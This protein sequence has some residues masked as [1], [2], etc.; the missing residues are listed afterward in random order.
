[1]FP[2]CFLFFINIVNDIVL[3]ISD[4]GVGISPE[5]LPTILSGNGT[6]TSGGTNILLLNLNML[7]Q[8]SL[9]HLVSIYVFLILRKI[10]FPFPYKFSFQ[11]VSIIFFLSKCDNCLA[12]LIIIYI[13]IKNCF[14]LRKIICLYFSTIFFPSSHTFNNLIFLCKCIDCR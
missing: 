5:K 1:M 6:S 9:F 10:S 4:D 13:S 14:S 12:A 2:K 3:L 7:S 11:N 8:L